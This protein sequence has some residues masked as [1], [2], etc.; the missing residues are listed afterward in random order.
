VRIDPPVPVERTGAP[1]TGRV[2]PCPVRAHESS[3]GRESAGPQSLRGRVEAQP[4]EGARA[5]LLH[6]L[7]TLLRSIAR[8][9]TAAP[10]EVR[11]PT[12]TQPD[13]RKSFDQCIDD[14]VTALTADD[15]SSD[16]IT[17]ALRAANDAG[18][19]TYRG[20][21]SPIETLKMAA[22]RL[23]RQPSEQLLRLARAFRSAVV[24][25]A[26]QRTPS[27]SGVGHLLTELQRAVDDELIDRKP[28]FVDKEVRAAL[29]LLKNGASGTQIAGALHAALESAAPLLKT[30]VLPAGRHSQAKVDQLVLR[31]LGSVPSHELI[32][33]LKHA[34]S[35]D[36][37][38]L[39]ALEGTVTQAIKAE[40]TARPT[41]LARLLQAG[42]ERPYGEL[43]GATRIDPHGF[44]NELVEL[45]GLR[46]EL[47]E[48]CTLHVLKSPNVAWLTDMEA[49]L[50]Q[51]VESI[52]QP[53][54]VDP[55]SF[56]TRQLVRLTHALH[57]LGLRGLAG[58]ALGEA[59]RARV[60]EHHERFRQGV[61]DLIAS[62]LPAERSADQTPQRLSALN[63]LEDA[64]RALEEAM[65]AF[66]REVPPSA[67]SAQQVQSDLIAECLQQHSEAAGARS[68][69][70]L[71]AALHVGA[72]LAL[73]ADE[74]DVGERFARMA[75]LVGQIMSAGAAGEFAAAELSEKERDALR[76]GFALLVP[77]DAPPTLQATRFRVLQPQA[78]DFLKPYPPP[79]AAD[80]KAAR[81]GAPLLKDV[82]SYCHSIPGAADLVQA[83][84]ALHDF[85]QVPTLEN[86]N[87]VTRA[88]A[89]VPRALV[90][91]AGS[92]PLVSDAAEQKLLEAQYAPLSPLPH[93]LFGDLERR[94][95]QAVETHVLPGMIEAVLDGRV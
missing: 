24:A 7:R 94:L 18:L 48:H 9:F 51:R 75:R 3:T 93:D 47:H 16:R 29:S 21:G 88:C 22:R 57:G 31:R 27:N 17:A 43:T 53:G 54:G 35:D 34:R 70:A 84:R 30:G 50:A 81:E 91:S 55:R 78:G 42:A 15:A 25:D 1:S 38:R 28:S 63:K 68:C 90:T 33:L 52:L 89:A 39:A 26:R 79:T 6:R 60:Q 76:D 2:S 67:S 92:K 83:M 71:I 8:C 40:I 73:Q 72:E 69:Q 56:S 37:A 95:T 11:R 49:K 58:A 85:T 20:G 19:R 10:T 59:Q 44:V 41:R 86:A 77:A 61:S 4:A 62:A 45:A 12:A 32:Q 23:R 13:T 74:T 82:L 5:G 36:L 65:L 87:S 80:V 46:Q 66:D 64:A 14:I